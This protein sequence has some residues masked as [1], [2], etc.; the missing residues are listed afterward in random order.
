M[1]TIILDKSKKSLSDVVFHDIRE[2]IETGKILPGS[3]I[4][5]ASLANKLNVSRVPI[6]DAMVRLESC[7][8]VERQLNVGARVVTLSFHKLIDIYHIRER[9]EGLAAR[10]CAEN[11]SRGG[12]DKLQGLLLSQ[13]KNIEEMQ[14]YYQKGGDLDIHYLIVNY[15]NNKHLIKLFNESLYYLIRVYRFQFG[16]RGSR[17]DGAYQEHKAVIDAIGNGDGEMAELLMRQHIRLSRNSIER[18]LEQGG[19]GESRKII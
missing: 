13:S 6:R 7:G 1:K 9:L 2:L 8:L 10:F 19:F 5:E 16:M 4:S 12:L 17:V 3:K 15:C 14:T 18:K 11:I